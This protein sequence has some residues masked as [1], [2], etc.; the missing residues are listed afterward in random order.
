MEGTLH[1][2]PTRPCLSSWPRSLFFDLIS[3]ESLPLPPSQALVYHSFDSPVILSVRAFPPTPTLPPPPHASITFA[4]ALSI[5]IH[6]PNTECPHSLRPPLPP[7]S[8]AVFSHPPAT[9][10][11]SVWRHVS[12]PLCTCLWSSSPLSV[13]SSPCACP[14]CTHTCTAHRQHW[15]EARYDTQKRKRSHLLSR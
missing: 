13:G 5:Y 4:H 2:S 7:P 8:H 11:P 12:A 1:C 3:A 15:G 14:C 10:V 9:R 6:L